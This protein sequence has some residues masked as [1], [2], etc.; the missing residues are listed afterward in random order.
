MNG[1][2]VS[3]RDGGDGV[4]A[5]AWTREYA[6]L[7]TRGLLGGYLAHRHRQGVNIRAIF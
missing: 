6:Y 7:V 5:L 1:R 2:S 3:N 4:H